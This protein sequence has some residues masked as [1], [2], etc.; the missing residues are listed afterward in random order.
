MTPIMWKRLASTG[1]AT[2]FLASHSAAAACT[3]NTTNTDGLQA[4]LQQGGEG[5]TLSLCSN[6]VYS[7]T[8]P[9]NYTAA[10]QEISTEGYP[11]DSSR[12]MLVVTGNLQT[13][14]VQ[15]TGANLDYARLIS[16]QVCRCNSPKGLC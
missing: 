5:Y 4:L 12:A 13:T 14:A 11:T 10:H 9:L 8:A 16:V 6:Q 15:G 1:L 7:L 3:S 2:L